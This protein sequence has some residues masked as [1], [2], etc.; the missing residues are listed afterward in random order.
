VASS[1]R[2]IGPAVPD[3]GSILIITAMREAG[4]RYERKQ[5]AR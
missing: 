1:W 2:G 3:P 5:L 4:E